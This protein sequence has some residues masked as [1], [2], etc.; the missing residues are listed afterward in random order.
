MTTAPDRLILAID[1]GTSAT[2]A[3]VVDQTGR[4]RSKATAPLAQNFPQPGWA[5]QDALEIWQSVQHAVTESL[6]GLPAEDVVAIGLSTQREST[7]LWDRAG[8]QPLGPVLGWQDTRGAALCATLREAGHAERVQAVTGLPLDAM[9]SASKATALLDQ[10]DPDRIRSRAGELCLGTV[11]SWL[12]W[13]LGGRHLIEAG[14]A[15]RTLLLDIDTGRWDPWL[16]DL[17]DVPAAVLPEVV[18]STGPFLAG[19]EPR[20]TAH[21]G[22]GDRGPRRLAR[23]PVRPRRVATRPGQGHVRHRF[24]GDGCH[25]RPTHPDRGRARRSPGI[26][27]RPATRWK[28]TSAR[29]ARRWSGWPD[30][31]RRH[32]RRSPRRRPIPVPA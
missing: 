25:H 27:A 24:V 14:N 31:S 17:F 9:F 29:A 19:H 20:R 21:A 6:A 10:H 16:L 30:C 1:Q 18:A 28:A 5:E 23:G 15:S 22:A 3:I 32:R 7:L 2:K 8:G 26:W 4:I 12:L 13:Q 11:D